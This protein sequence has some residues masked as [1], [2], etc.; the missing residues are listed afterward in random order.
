MNTYWPV[1]KNLETEFNKIANYIHIDDKQLA[2]YSSKIAD[3][4]LRTVVEIESLSKKMYIQNV[5]DV[6]NSDFIKYEDALKFLNKKWLLDKKKIQLSALNCFVSNR[7]MTPFIKNTIRTGKSSKTYSWNNSYQDLK[8]DREKYIESGNIKGLIDGL[9]AL[10][11]LNI[12]YKDETLFLGKES[13][14]SSISPSIWSNI[15]SIEIHNWRAHIP[16]YWKRD[17]FDECTYFTNRTQK[18]ADRLNEESKKYNE[19]IWEIVQ[20]M[21]KVKKYLAETPS[22][23]LS[24]NWLYLA[25]N[26]PDEYVRILSRALAAAPINHETTEYEAV[27]NKNQEISA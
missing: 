8:H 1:Y 4:I 6:L 7:T 2:T 20:N 27:L 14:G 11:L 21:P 15:F 25:I 10:F 26:N 23:N 18:S 16:E 13:S 19:K 24:K 5:G 22:N 12:Y 3:L 9:S 17:D